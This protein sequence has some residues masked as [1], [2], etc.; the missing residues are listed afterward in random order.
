[1][2]LP[3]H[4]EEEHQDKLTGF[5]RQHSFG[6]L[7]SRHEQR[8][9]ASHLPFLHESGEGGRGK[10][11]GHMARANPQWQSLADGQ[12]VLVVFQ[13]PHAYISPSWYDAPG[14]PTWNYAVVHVCGT[15]RLIEDGSGLWRLLQRMTE[16]YEAA[17][18][19]PWQPKLSETER[20]RL[21]GMIVGFEIEV[22][23]IQG[24]FKLSQNRSPQI[25]ANVIHHLRAGASPDG[26]AVAALMEQAQDAG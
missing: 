10:L 5:I 9:F 22:T 3:G 25:R 15:A 20:V 23:D 26:V 2:Y 12:E 21:L 11:L 17:F 18:E 7:V 1:M 16:H 6:L 19:Q 14:V 4:F 24:K 8:P 13:G